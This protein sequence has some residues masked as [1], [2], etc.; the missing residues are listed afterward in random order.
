MRC[1]DVLVSHLP[2]NQTLVL[3]SEPMCL[4]QQVTSNTTKRSLPYWLSKSSIC[5]QWRM[6]CLSA[7]LPGVTSLCLGARFVTTGFWPQSRSRHCNGS[8]V[9]DH[10]D[11]G[12]QT[13]VHVSS[14]KM[15]T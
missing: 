7:W 11:H 15:K 13:A 4:S 2:Q 1:H 6:F 8:R 3:A 5:S 12:R 10:S 9:D 14:I